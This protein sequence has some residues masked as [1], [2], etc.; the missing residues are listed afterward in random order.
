[1]DGQPQAEFPVDR[2]LAGQPRALARAISIVEDNRSGAAAIIM[3]VREHVGKALVVGFTGPPGA[4]KSTLI[5]AVV[6]ELRK[7]DKTVC[8][9]AV[10]PSS[11]IS[12]GAVL[13]DRVRMMRHVED[14]GVFTRSV[15]ARGHLGGLSRAAT[16]IVDVMDAAGRDVIILETVGTGQSEVEIAKVA[17]IKVVVSA[18]GLG[19]DIQAMKAGILEIAD[20]L[21]VNKSDLPL[22]RTTIRHLE[23]MLHLRKESARDV[24]LVAT[25]ALNGTGI[26]EL[27][28]V[29]LRLAGGIAPGSGRRHHRQ[30]GLADLL[31]E[32][33]GHR[34]ADFVAKS[35]N[36]ALGVL[37]NDLASGAVELD[38]AVNR[39][40]KIA[41]A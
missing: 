35:P 27:V 3:G 41:G 13:G 31:R 12:G 40:F 32:A 22:A 29:M 39:L 9:L 17:D 10:D 14:P 16:R 36:E 23:S 7:R 6:T 26:V 8:V 24:P 20:I 21:V 1:M 33:A 19:D 2:L 18:P 5:D 30:A 38:E 25:G 4:G 37:C 28:D 34:L 15:A 11:P